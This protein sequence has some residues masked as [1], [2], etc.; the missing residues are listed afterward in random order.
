MNIDVLHLEIGR[1]R[2]REDDILVIKIPSRFPKEIYP[3]IREEA[4]KIHKRVFIMSDLFD[5]GVIN[6]TDDEF[7]SLF[8]IE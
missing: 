2:L 7:E 4:Q 5:I 6:K 1:L 3:K 8:R